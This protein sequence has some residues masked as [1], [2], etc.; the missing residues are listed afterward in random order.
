MSEEI[1]AEWT[2]TDAEGDGGLP[3]VP[4][5]AQ[6]GAERETVPGLLAG[7]ELVEGLGWSVVMWAVDR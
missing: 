2:A 7:I 4:P 5:L 3:Y 1:L 6:F